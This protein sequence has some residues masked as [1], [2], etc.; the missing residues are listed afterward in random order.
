MAQI[1]IKNA[2]I[3]LRDGGAGTNQQEL[4]ITIG[5]GNL[6]Y[7]ERRN[8]DY[9]LD[10]GVLDEVREGDEVPVEVSLDAT[11]TYI[12]ANNVT[13]DAP[14]IE[15]ALKK[16]GP[17]ATWISSDS[18]TCRPFALDIVIEYQPDCSDSSANKPREVITLPDFRYEQIDHDLRA[19]T[20]AITG[21]CNTTEATAVRE[22]AV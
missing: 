18:D 6:T 22:A 14:T 15:D 8:I 11:W 4:E 13:G 17:A 10:R 5:E 12:T 9:T 3:F 21:Q 20:F 16:R 2:T 1:D 7:T 19:G